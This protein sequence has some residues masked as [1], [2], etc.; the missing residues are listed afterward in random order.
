[1]DQY[2]LADLKEE[3]GLQV[4][5]VMQWWPGSC[6]SETG[7]QQYK[8]CSRALHFCVMFYFFSIELVPIKKHL[9]KCDDKEVSESMM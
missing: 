6:V 8:L 7:T 2:Q 9:N 1:M 5:Y 3:I 4:I